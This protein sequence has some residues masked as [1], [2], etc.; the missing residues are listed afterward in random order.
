MDSLPSDLLAVSHFPP[1]LNS[2]RDISEIICPLILN[3]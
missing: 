3:K 1:W 2:V